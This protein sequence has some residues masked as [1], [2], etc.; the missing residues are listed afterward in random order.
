MIELVALI[1]S[2]LSFR[3]K[4]KEQ[5]ELANVLTIMACIQREYT[6][7]EIKGMLDNY[8]IIR[9]HLENIVAVFQNSLDSED[10]KLENVGLT[11][12]IPQASDADQCLIELISCHIE[13]LNVM[14]QA[15][16]VTATLARLKKPV[17]YFT[18]ELKVQ[19]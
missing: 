16:Q 8:P 2:I 1:L 15:A 19:T 7:F 11:R 17:V 13:V 3:Q 12:R 4:T 10:L 6:R 18:G 14:Y 9:E 5:V